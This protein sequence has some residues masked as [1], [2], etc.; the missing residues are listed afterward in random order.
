VRR[1][2]QQKQSWRVDQPVL[3]LVSGSG[4]FTSCQTKKKR[5][6]NE[7]SEFSSPS[8]LPPTTTHTSSNLQNLDQ[9][10][11]PTPKKN[12]TQVKQRKNLSTKNRRRRRR[13]EEEEEEARR[14]WLCESGIGGDEGGEEEYLLRIR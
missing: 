12:K 8:H 14:D 13:L 10:I 7:F 1:T 6:E 4:I 9:S 3:W 5:K 2:Q 11:H